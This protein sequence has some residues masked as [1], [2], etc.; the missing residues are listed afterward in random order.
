MPLFVMLAPVSCANPLGDV[1]GHEGVR[2]RC[3]LSMVNSELRIAGYWD[4]SNGRKDIERGQE[5]SF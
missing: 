4:A 2:H 1:F 5:W 3:D